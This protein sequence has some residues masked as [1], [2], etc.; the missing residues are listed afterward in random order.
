VSVSATRRLLQFASDSGYADLPG[1]A[2][3]ESKRAML[4]FLGVAIGAA[5]DDAP[6]IALETVCELGGAQQAT[7]L[8]Y[9]QRTSAVNVALVD[10]ILSHVL[11]FDDT[12][13]PTILHPT[14]PV[15]AAG[16]PIAE[17]KAKSG[18]D[19]IAAHVLAF[20][21][22]ARA[23]LALY[24]EHYDRGWHM[25]G[26]TG[27]LGA[28]VSAARLLGLDAGQLVHAVGIAATQ[29]AGHREQFG[30]MTKSLHSGK[31]A[32]NG[33]LSALLA[34]RGYTSA[35]E[36]LEGRRGMFHVMS[37]K[38]DLA[39]LTEGLGERWEIFRNGF[40]PYSCGVVTHPGIDAVRRLGSEHGLRPEDVERIDLQVHPLVLELTGK[41]DPRTGLEGK[42][43]IAFATAIAL[44][45]GTARQRQF[46]DE[47]VRRPDVMALRDRVHPKADTTL[48][49]TEAIAVATL[50]DGRQ[51]REHVTAATG[52]P[53]NPI[54]DAELQSKFMDLVEPVIG[55]SA[56]ARIIEMVG[57]LEELDNVG[58]LLPF[59]VKSA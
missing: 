43:S 9:G 52:T 29:A 31:A 53:E 4:D 12:H 40:K 42:F 45:E 18:R 21:V 35:D 2:V 36:S 5:H 32:S 54:S 27:T 44:L 58:V 51:I 1:E 8:A 46:T 13:I 30:S 56:G 39:E 59:T 3:R 49:H 24:P 37:T 10:G 16:L 33:V 14:G 26:T 47:K 41:T 6:R 57:R 19:L 38:V 34:S 48:S 22:E 11:D 20:E 50:R 17:W 7:V 15:M 28:A 23:S 55:Q 25:T